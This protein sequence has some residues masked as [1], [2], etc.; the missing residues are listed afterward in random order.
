MAA[1]ENVFI[2]YKRD[3]SSWMLATRLQRDLAKRGV[4]VWRDETNIFAGTEWYAAVEKGIEECSEFLVVL[5][6]A[7][8][9]P[10]HVMNE[11]HRAHKL[12]KRIIPLLRE[13]CD[14]PI[15]IETANQVD[16]SGR[17]A[18]GFAALLD[19]PEVPKTALDGFLRWTRKIQKWWAEAAI[20]IALLATL[21]WFFE[22]SR[23]EFSVAGIALSRRDSAIIIRVENHGGQASTIV[24]PAH[25]DFPP[26]V[27]VRNQ[28]LR[29]VGDTMRVI[30]GHSFRQ[31]H[32]TASG[33]EPLPRANGSVPDNL[34]I[35]A[36]LRG[37][38]A[39]LR[40]HIFESSRT[41]KEQRFEFPAESIRRFVEHQLP[42]AVPGVER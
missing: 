42:S 30:P 11:L 22:P 26:G 37:R 8:V 13:P 9:K 2:S 16:F 29:F 5:S 23:T 33:L 38:R 25:I 14:T 4:K 6:P 34:H 39:I 28:Q 20:A 12:G 35:G 41:A 36:L 19:L 27:P 31:I 3:L 32:L 17:Y 24:A 1:L 15:V 18:R 7:S 40:L 10:G 21:F